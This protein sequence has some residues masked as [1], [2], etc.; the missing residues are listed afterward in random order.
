MNSHSS[1]SCRGMLILLLMPCIP[2]LCRAQESAPLPTIRVYTNSV[3]VGATVTNTSGNI[4]KGLQRR[5][6]RVFDDGVEQPLTSFLSFGEP[7]QVVL[8][9]EC[10]PM[11]PFLKK[12]E[13]ETA[14]ILL[15]SISPVDRVAIVGYSTVPTLVLDFT[16]DKSQARS[17]LQSMSFM[18]LGELNLS[19]SVENTLDQLISVPGKKS[20]VAISSGVDT[21]PLAKWQLI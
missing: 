15:D 18:S 11:S 13:L 4:V 5:D 12:R 2:A 17:A 19:S 6:F 16:A 1:I 9:L 8:L 3:R 14:E 10:G 21:T 7:A 20:V